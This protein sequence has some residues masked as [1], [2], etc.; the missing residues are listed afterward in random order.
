M[1][2]RII[3]TAVTF[4]LAVSLIGCGKREQTE[5]YAGSNTAEVKKDGVITNTI[6]DS[7]DSEYYDEALLEE[8]ALR[9]AA[10][11]NHENGEG[12]IS[13][14]KL[15]VKKEKVMLTMEY[16]TAE[17]FA[18]FNGYPFFWGTVEEAFDDGYDFAEVELLEAGFAPKKGDA[19]E[20]PSIREEELKQMGSRKIIIVDVPDDERLTLETS[21]K[22]LYISGAEYVKKN[23]AVIDGSVKQPAYIV[24]K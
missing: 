19:Q 9:E 22:I 10:E 14:K 21:G 6:E 17:D 2:R 16:R 24:F 23:L 5:N 3:M 13:I 12:A 20:V 18:D 11:Y 7:F 8:F 15:E 1:N 4:L